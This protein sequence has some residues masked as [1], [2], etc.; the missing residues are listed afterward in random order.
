LKKHDEKLRIV[1]EP[2]IFDD[3]SSKDLKVLLNEIGEYI[4]ECVDEAKIQPQ[5]E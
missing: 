5:L 1:C 2:S 4:K 3:D